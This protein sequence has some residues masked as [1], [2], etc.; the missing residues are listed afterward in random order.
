MNN[1]PSASAVVPSPIAVV[2]PEISF[3][4]LFTVNFSLRLYIFNLLSMKFFW[5]VVFTTTL[6]L[7]S[8]PEIVA[9]FPDNTNVSLVIAPIWPLVPLLLKWTEYL[10]SSN[11]AHATSVKSV[12]D[13]FITSWL[14]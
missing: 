9:L 11:A 10:S 3:L 8:N 6:L 13:V 2:T 4:D 14:Q 7:S 12:S 5:T 1:N